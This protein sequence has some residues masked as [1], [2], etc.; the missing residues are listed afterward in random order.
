M[1]DLCHKRGGTK[2]SVS[3]LVVVWTS[4][5]PEVERGSILPAAIWAQPAPQRDE[6]RIGP[7]TAAAALGRTRVRSKER[8]DGENV[9]A[10]CRASSRR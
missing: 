4:V 3:Y 9:D 6:V 8:F 5:G 1:R 7:T 2:H 10:R